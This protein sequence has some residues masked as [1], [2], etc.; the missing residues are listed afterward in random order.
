MNDLI[1]QRG[2]KKLGKPKY[3]FHAITAYRDNKK[4]VN[5]YNYKVIHDDVIKDDLRN[6]LNRIIKT[7]DVHEEIE[8]PRV[9]VFITNSKSE[10]RKLPYAAYDGKRETMIFNLEIAGR[11]D[12]DFL[13]TH[14]MCHHFVLKL[15]RGTGYGFVYICKKYIFGC[16]LDEGFNNFFTEQVCNKKDK[17]TYI[18][19]TFIAREFANIIGIEAANRLY[20]SSAISII[21][22]DFN[23]KLEK[24]YPTK[25]YEL[26]N[27]KGRFLD[28]TPFD[29]FCGN[30]EYVGYFWKN[31]QNDECLAKLRKTAKCVIEM[32]N[33]YAVLT[34]TTNSRKY[35]ME[36]KSFF[37][38]YGKYLGVN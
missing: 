25:K 32:L 14:E 30:L 4:S 23:K 38:N 22:E 7:F 31:P 19:P 21:R 3:F 12:E 18:F 33:Y 35:I 28:F 15:S 6:T 10:A 2:K 8:L 13:V 24:Y 29:V 17:R 16:M 11:L 27:Y 9:A 1:L 34:D 26:D 5:N 20:K 36:Q 37:E